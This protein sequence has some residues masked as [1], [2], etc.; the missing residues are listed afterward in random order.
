MRPHSSAPE[1]NAEQKRQHLEQAAAGLEAQRAVL[2][3]LVVDSAL[4]ALRRQLAELG[5]STD[6]RDRLA[7]E[8]KLITVM[9][10]DISGY[11]ALAETIDPERARDLLN[12]CFEH[13]VPMVE[14][15]GGTIDKFV[16]DEIVA[17]FGAPVAHEN[18]AE[19]AC[20]AALEMMAALAD[21]NQRKKADLALHF[22]INT[23]H[24]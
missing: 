8:R 17:L 11:T 2:G 10:A 7:G 3:D 22:G 12:D 15:Y 14:K 4:E 6:G 20:A 21:F 24:V 1:E 9:F 13:L 18:D 5:P 23:G 19:R 16:G